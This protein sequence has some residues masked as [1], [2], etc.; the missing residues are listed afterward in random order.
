MKN[1]VLDHFT[2]DFVSLGKNGE[3]T[4][5][6]GGDDFWNLPAEKLDEIGQ[7]WLITEFDFEQDWTT[8]EMHSHGEEIVYLLAGAMDLTIEK[9][10]VRQTIELRSKGLAII[11]RNTW[12]TAKVLKPSKMLVITF[13]KE[14]QIKPV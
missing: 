10:G 6:E 11:P 12:H 8:W 13:G 14:T 4:A 9:E 5:F 3:I 7:N 1:K 2:K